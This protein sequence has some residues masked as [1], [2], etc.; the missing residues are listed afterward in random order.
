MIRAKTAAPFVLIAAI[1][2]VAAAQT[3]KNPD[4]AQGSRTSQTMIPEIPAGADPMDRRP[5]P[6]AGTPGASALRQPGAAGEESSNCRV[7]RADTDTG[8]VVVCEE[9]D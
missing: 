1:A 8:F 4:D 9:A 6:A 5:D 7:R 3:V 2:A